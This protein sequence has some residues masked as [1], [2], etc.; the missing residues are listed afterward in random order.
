M[1]VVAYARDLGRSIGTS[2]GELAADMNRPE[3]SRDVIQTGPE[4][5]LRAQL[6]RLG[7]R[8]RE[9]RF[10][11]A[12]NPCVGAAVFAPDGRVLGEG[13]TRPWGGNHAEIEALDAAQFAGASG[14]DLDTL[15]VTLEPCSSEG[16][17]GPCTKAIVE[18]GVR[19]VVVGAL[20]PD[21]RHR[22][23]G[24]ELLRAAGIEVEL[25]EGVTRLEDIAPHFLAWVDYERLRRPRPWMIAKWAQTRTG[26]LQ[27]PEDVGEGRWISSPE[28]LAEVQHLR[29]H[30]DA[31]VTGIGTVRA[32]DPRLT[33]R[34]EA[35]EAGA[36][37][38]LRIVLDTELGTPP[39]ARL[40][41]EP[42]AGELAGPVYI[43]CRA[44]AAPQRH[45]ALLAA[46]ARVH[47]L[48]PDA[49]GHLHLREAL[50]W[51]WRFG[52]RRTLLEAGPTLL[53]AFFDAGFVDQIRVYTG[54]INGGR[55]E[56]L[57]ELLAHDRLS[58]RLDREVGEDS[59][60]EAFAVGPRR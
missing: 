39:D 11:V 52:V 59:V 19:R 27:P 60:F 6:A 49:E 58:E 25:L 55:G 44:G 7:R 17:T 51:M 15:L 30:V 34:G 45:R 40:F 20:D 24:L 8:A 54:A 47:G 31:I 18:A 12:P 53:R 43:L 23:Q 36:A 22:G 26:Q 16:K 13:Y 42:G 9:R 35:A 3:G 21:P 1:V 41:Q 14:E 5:D 48:R 2:G 33:V 32:D 50:E 38:P 28:S 29:A 10:E 4:V 57:A 37:P 46:G 56:S